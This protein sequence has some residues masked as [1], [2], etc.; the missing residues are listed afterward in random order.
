MGARSLTAGCSLNTNSAG[1]FP[2]LP[3]AQPMVNKPILS[4]QPQASTK[5]VLGCE[6]WPRPRGEW[7][8]SGRAD[9]TNGPGCYRLAIARMPQAFPKAPWYSFLRR[10]LSSVALGTIRERPSR[11]LEQ[12]FPGRWRVSG[13]SSRRAAV[14]ARPSAQRPPFFPQTLQ[15]VVLPTLIAFPFIHGSNV[16][17][18]VIVLTPLGF[19]RWSRVAIADLALRADL[20]GHSALDFS[21]GAWECLQQK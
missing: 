6:R 5:S 19:P 7:F 16:S 21:A 11:G 3:T 20:P 12:L 18:L 2:C 15:R 9:R 1:F 13:K 14:Q 10:R 17:S 4:E 8:A